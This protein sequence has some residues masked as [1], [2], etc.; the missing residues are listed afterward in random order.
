MGIKLRRLVGHT[1]GIYLAEFLLGGAQI[2]SASMDGTIRI[3]DSA[4]GAVVRCIEI[5][6]EDRF[7]RI[8]RLFPNGDQIAA[9]TQNVIQIW[10]LHSG[11]VQMT[12]AHSNRIVDIAISADGAWIIASSVDRI[13]RLWNAATGAGVGAFKT[14]E[15]S[16]K[17]MFS[18]DQKYIFTSIG[19]I[20][21]PEEYQS[22]RSS[23]N[24]DGQLFTYDPAYFIKDGWLCTQH[25]MKRICWI[26]PAWR[27]R[28]YSICDTLA[29]HDNC[30]VFITDNGQVVFLDTTDLV[31]YLND[32]IGIPYRC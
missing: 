17:L 10:D 19:P 9:G 3:W 13:V 6:N 25:P 5:E 14:G 15:A 1:G 16:Y 24:T 31:D 2:I 20:T 28:F 26:P 18:C 32:V 21:I 12:I 29:W 8:A 4:T 22:I 27:T 23:E 7:C 30:V 11:S